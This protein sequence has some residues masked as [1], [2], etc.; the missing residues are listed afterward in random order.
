[1]DV[2]VTTRALNIIDLHSKEAITGNGCALFL[3][4]KNLLTVD[5]MDL[6]HVFTKNLSVPSV[7]SS[8]HGDPSPVNVFVNMYGI[9][10]MNYS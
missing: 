7:T 2:N 1:M 6:G 8:L 9:H 5:N 10:I 3:S 4:F